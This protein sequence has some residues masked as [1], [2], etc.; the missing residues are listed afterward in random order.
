MAEAALKA[1][2]EIKA[3]PE[4]KKSEGSAAGAAPKAEAPATPEEFLRFQAKSD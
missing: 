4:P 3:E 1:E 2:A